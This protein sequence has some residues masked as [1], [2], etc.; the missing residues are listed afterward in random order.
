MKSKLAI[1]SLIISLSPW[2][3]LI[4]SILF[5]NLTHQIYYMG[6]E[7][8]MIASLLISLAG[9]ITSSLALNNIKKMKLDGENIATTALVISIIT[10]LIWS[11]MPFVRGI[12]SS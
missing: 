10:F 12:F 3:L 11:G 2:L 6:Q 8:I 5:E 4:L 9:I 1:L 7:L